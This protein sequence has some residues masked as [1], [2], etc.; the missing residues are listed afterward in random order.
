MGLGVSGLIQGLEPPGEEDL[1]LITPIRNLG[2]RAFCGV[3][4]VRL[5]ESSRGFESELPDHVVLEFR[6]VTHW[7]SRRAKEL[8][9][10]QVGPAWV[11]LEAE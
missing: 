7:R 10:S 3:L 6:P 4:G 8:P 11:C 1:I 5:L 9:R 2:R